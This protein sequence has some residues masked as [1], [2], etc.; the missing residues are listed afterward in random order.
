MFSGIKT[1]EIRRKA[2]CLKKKMFL[3]SICAAL[4]IGGY[5]GFYG[6][7]TGTFLLLILTGLAK[8]DVRS[9]SGTT[10]V[11]NLSSNIAALATFFNKWKGFDSLRTGVRAFLHC[12]P[13]YRIRTCS[14]KWIK[15]CAPGGFS[16]AFVFI[17]ENYKRIGNCYEMEKIY[18]DHHDRGCGFSQQHV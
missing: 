8:M 18:A 5:D 2:A 9:A 12:R 17:C 7:G 13:L 15:D 11:I 14:E 1:W 10:K 16:G 6:P 3:I 4:V